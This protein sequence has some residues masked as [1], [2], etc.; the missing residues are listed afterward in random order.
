MV[1]QTAVVLFGRLVSLE[2]IAS[3]LAANFPVAE[4]SAGPDEAYWQSGEGT[5]EVTSSA[6]HSGGVAAQLFHRRWPDD[7]GDP[8]L[9][10]ELF[11]AWSRHDFGLLTF[12]YG[13]AR[14]A[15]QPQAPN[16]EHVAFVK[17]SWSS[18]LPEGE[19][20]P[21]E[22]DDRRVLSELSELSRVAT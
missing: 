8:D 18:T 9:D 4:R 21:S 20:A 5:L 2:S 11:D 6:N 17:L 12:P 14:A 3:A 16:P 1:L 7:M 22:P 10:P 19:T 15:A 13:L